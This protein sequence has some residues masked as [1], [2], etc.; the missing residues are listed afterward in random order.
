MKLIRLQSDTFVVYTNF[1][2]YRTKQPEYVL[3]LENYI[4]PARIASHYIAV[5]RTNGSIVYILK[6]YMK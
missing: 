3:M 1:E 4:I 6:A 2:S 5:L